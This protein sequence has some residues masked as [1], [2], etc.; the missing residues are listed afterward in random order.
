MGQWVGSGCGSGWSRGRGSGVAV[1]GWLVGGA[2]G[3]E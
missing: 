3:R 1:G 2:V